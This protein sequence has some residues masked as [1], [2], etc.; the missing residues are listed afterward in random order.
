MYIIWL[1]L[2]SLRSLFANIFLDIS[3]ILTLC[4]DL[5]ML[6]HIVLYLQKR[7]GK[8]FYLSLPLIFCLFFTPLNVGF[9]SVFNVLS[10]VVL[11]K[12]VEKKLF[13]LSDFLIC[14]AILG[15][16]LFL[17]SSNIIQDSFMEGKKGGI[18]MKVHRLGFFNPNGAGLFFYN[19]ILVCAI[20]NI[21]FL[22]SK[23]FDIFL[24]CVS[25]LIYKLTGSRT[26]Y[27]SELLYFACRI[28]F[29]MNFFSRRFRKIYVLIP[30]ICL[31]VIVSG[32][33]IYEKFPLM[34]VIF[35]GR[36]SCYNRMLK[37]ATPLSIILGVNVGDYPLDSAFLTLFS[38][39]GMI[40]V[41]T[42]FSVYAKAINNMPV[43]N[44][45][46]YM[47]FIISLIVSGMAENTFSTVMPIT[48]LFYKI[49]ADQFIFPIRF[50]KT[51]FM[52]KIFGT[53]SSSKNNNCSSI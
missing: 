25:V 53:S 3:T 29:S 47:P 33:F 4:I 35:S 8:L 30:S 44:I 11:L 32:F 5:I 9:L 23:F 13:I 20:F 10:F 21:E 50:Y 15:L 52:K 27:Y 45:K 12:N 31:L 14:I 37:D 1:L 42:F 16:Y 38:S 26:F 40:F 18:M 24:L 39:G 36:Y 17:L 49:L 48:V 7:N 43:K 2:I 41:W 22:K 46:K 28:I 51:G 34:D 19:I 6:L